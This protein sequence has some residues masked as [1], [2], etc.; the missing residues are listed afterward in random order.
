[1]M[2]AKRTLVAVALLSTVVVPASA[3]PL[4]HRS[5]GYVAEPGFVVTVFSETGG[6]PS[7]LAFGP[8]TRK[9]SDGTRLYVADNT[10][11]SVLAID[12][13]GGVGG[14]PAVF[15]DGFRG[16]LG[17]VAGPDGS[18]Y[19]ADA[20]AAREG[21]WGLRGYGRVWRVQDLD[22]DGVGEKKTVV[23]KDLP[24][25]R[26]N[27]NGMAFGP[28]GMLYVTNGNATDDG[29]EG[30]EYEV[31][32]WGGS[33]IRIDPNWKNVSAA[34][35]NPRRSLIAQGWR[36][37]YDVA[38]S[39]IDPTKAFVPMNG[40]DDARKG[41]TGENPADPDLEDSDDLLFMTDIDD[42]K[43]EDFGYPSCLYNVGE[44]GDLKPYD[45]PNPDVIKKFGACNERKVPRPVSSFGLHTSSDGL[46]F[47]RTDNWGDDYSNDL[48]V[49][50]WGS[51]FGPP[52]GHD[53]VRVQLNE[54][55]TKVESQ[56]VFL[57]GPVPLDLTFDPNGVMYVA[58]YGGSILRVDRV[59]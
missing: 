39:P 42:S 3:R 13:L 7:S 18:V 30:G 44:K 33:L 52:R 51:L 43:I 16:P 22:G 36:N 6:T 14:Q 11:N 54:A 4:S 20:E 37:V 56:E 34:D 32:P 8:D 57:F 27:T 29:L 1:M 55:G 12:D 49:A 19:V 24:N 50:E 59:P 5:S 45:S 48:F 10:G 15:A 21:P 31:D 58:D 40:I 25:G 53:V 46:E 2:R 26:H 41:S 23:I 17:V 38:F 28:D 35:L 47:Q 9:G